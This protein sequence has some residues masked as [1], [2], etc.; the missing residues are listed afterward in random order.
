MRPPDA[1]A[2]GESAVKRICIAGANS[3]IGDSFRDYL[4]QFGGTYRV[5]V[6]ETKGLIPSAAHFAGY[7]AVF[8]VT[9]IAHVRETPENHS[10]YFQV[11]RDLVI[12]MAEAAKAAGVGQFILLS[13]MAVYGMARGRIT[14][15]TVPHP[16]T[17]YG[18]SKLQAD[19]AVRKLADDRFRFACLRP[20]MVYGKGCKGNYQ[21]LR[22]FAL[23]FPVFPDYPNQR[24]MVYVGNLC[25]FV[26]ECIDSGKDGLFFPQNAEYANTADM[27]RRIARAHGRSVLLTG[28]FNWAIRLCGLG[29]VKKV[30]GDLTYDPVDRVDAFGWE[31]SI[32]L[33][34]ESEA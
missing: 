5:D 7:D 32:R 2:S 8:C 13:S 14:K 34:E 12:S 31:E 30:F 9:G 17:A 20:P 21:R 4:R 11:N 22:A 19:E 23:K 28:A 15:D 26:K 33:T 1:E 29:V 10:F 16:A 27:V 18:E 25:A 3:Y 6:L 24:S